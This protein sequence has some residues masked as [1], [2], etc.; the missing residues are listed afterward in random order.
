MYFTFLCFKLKK[1]L[2]RNLPQN[3]KIYVFNYV[4]AI[5][6]GIVSKY[7]LQNITMRGIKIRIKNKTLN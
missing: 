4:D 1:K 6:I 7:L 5:N 3:V 2:M